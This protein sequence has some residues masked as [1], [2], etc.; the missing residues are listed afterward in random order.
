MQRMQHWN[1]KLLSRSGVSICR[2]LWDRS[3]SFNIDLSWIELSW[4][5]WCVT[6]WEMTSGCCGR[7]SL[8]HGRS[9]E[10]WRADAE[11]QWD[12]GRHQDALVKPQFGA[13]GGVRG[14][15]GSSLHGGGVLA[16]KEKGG[17]YHYWK[18]AASW[19]VSVITLI[20]WSRRMLGTK[21]VQ[22]FAWYSSAPVKCLNAVLL[23]SIK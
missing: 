1:R 11:E 8:E 2:P 4:R 3:E 19:V 15:G 7:A 23:H 10:G 14:R 20:L 6:K 22:K 21:Y 9:R 12:E 13:S 18:V 5:E 16:W 17:G